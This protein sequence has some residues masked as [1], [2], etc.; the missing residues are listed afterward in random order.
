MKKILLAALTFSLISTPALAAL[1][2]FETVPNSTPVD[3]L[4][5][6]DQ[7]KSLYGVTFSTSISGFWPT[8]EK[9]GSSDS[10][11]GFLYDGHGNHSDSHD[12]EALG[13]SGLGLGDY[14]LRIGTSDLFNGSG[15]DLIIDYS[16]PVAAASAQIWDI[17][18]HSNGTEQWTVNAFNSS[19][20]L[21]GQQVSPVGV[22]N[23]GLGTLD[24]LPWTW[25]F[26]RGQ[27]DISQIV[28]NFTGT[29]TTGVGLA[30][31]NFYTDST[32][33]P[34]PATMLL[35]GA[36]LASLVGVRLRNKK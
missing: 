12:V 36:G 28:L 30:F 11:H 24:G 25:S 20:Q 29:K 16:A 18:T 22:A 33:V 26:Q 19:G 6:G 14:F 10:G 34:E 8:L 9:R 3:K 5:I 21:V 31:D 17:D 35:F 2:N 23:G 7:F 1:I 32:P 27:S 4:Q 15:L 13:Y